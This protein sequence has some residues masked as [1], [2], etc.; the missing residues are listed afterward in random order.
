MSGNT[1]SKE[2][3]PKIS[4][5]WLARC[6]WNVL[7]MIN[8]IGN[9]AV[10][11]YLFCDIDM[12]WAEELRQKLM[13]SGKRVTVTAILLKAIAIAQRTHPA[14]R[15]ALLPW[16]RT[17][18][19]H[20]IVAGFTVERFVGT[21]PTV[22]FGAIDGPDRKPIDQIAD[23]LRQYAERGLD[24]VPHLDIQ[25]R[26]QN[27]PW[28]FRR[29]IL[30]LGQNY[31]MVRLQHMGATFGLSS[32]GKHGVKAVIPPC[33]STSTFG[34]GE[35]EQRAVVKDGNVVVRPIMTLTLNF[36]HRL[37]DGAP[38]ARFLRD[39]KMLVEGGLEAHIKEELM[40]AAAILE[41]PRPAPT[42][43]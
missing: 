10:P 18:T 21:Q 7:D 9:G 41:T 24:E 34:V 42:Y 16:G 32:L 40:S 1:N 27:M 23:E 35:V 14:S 13:A 26:F 43:S 33:V 17:V 5:S 4:F 39:I 36:D 37:I 2:N 19:F 3:K 8:I 31:P 22:F 28:L 6:R 20:D 15:S 11:T 25:N 12:G 29:F 30:W 38:A